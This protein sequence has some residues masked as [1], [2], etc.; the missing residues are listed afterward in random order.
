MRY[1][2]VGSLYHTNDNDTPYTII[3]YRNVPPTRSFIY[4]RHDVVRTIFFR[5]RARRVKSINAFLRST[6]FII[7]LLFFSRRYLRSVF[8]T[9]RYRVERGE[10][11]YTYPLYVSSTSCCSRTY[12]RYESSGAHTRFAH[13]NTN[14]FFSNFPC[15]PYANVR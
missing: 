8:L 2:C 9:F 14:V 1:V 3:T 10:S 6:V 15:R 12:E 7:Y 4:H 11:L 13:N 5:A